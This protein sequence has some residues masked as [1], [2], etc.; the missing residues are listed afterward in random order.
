MPDTVRACLFDLDGVL[1]KTALIHA[2]A[3]QEM[4]DAFLRQ[5]AAQAR[6]PFVAFDPV[7]DYDR[8]VDGRPRAQGVKS[9]LASRGIELPAGSA[10]DSPDA[11][12]IG[13]LAQR[14][15]EILQRRIATDGVH[16]YPGSVQYVR[17]VTAAGLARAVVS[18]S[19][20]CREMLAGAALD[21]YFQV[22]VDGVVAQRDKLAGKPAP[23]T[24][25]AA[26]RQLGV[27]PGAAAVFEDAQAG[28]AAGKA[29][30]FGW[31]IGV[32]RTGQADAL[33]EKGA[34]IVVKDLAELLDQQ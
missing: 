29:G 4:F 2:A 14:K 23:D 27:P 16:A 19:A 9:F 17:A 12:T 8:Y 22:V 7:S 26:A 6:Q 25:L 34:D 11:D 21:G 1:T 5:H 13:G 30:G 28:V 3:W 32:D 15:N 33:R 31:V 10:D 18:A 24:Y 20:H